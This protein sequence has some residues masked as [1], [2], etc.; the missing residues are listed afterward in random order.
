MT[1]ETAS[2][3]DKINV[4]FVVQEGDA[5]R[6]QRNFSQAQLA[7]AETVGATVANFI[8]AAKSS[9][10]MAIYDFLLQ[11]EAA[12][13]VVGALNAAAQSGKDVRIA[14]FEAHNQ[15]PPES[16][17]LLGGDPAIIDD[18]LGGA[19]LQDA[20]RRRGVR[21]NPAEGTL[22][23]P[24]EGEPITAP[25]NL[26]H[27]KYI[28]RDGLTDEAAVLAGSANFT[29]DAWALQDNNI[30]IL[31]NCQELSAY[32]E[33]DF[34]EM[35]QS[36]LISNTGNFDTAD[37]EVGGIPVQVL[38]A[39]GRGRQIGGE[40]AARIE[41]AKSRLIVASM[42]ISSAPIM[43]AIADRMHRV[44]KFGG[45]F[46]GAEMRMVL[47]EWERSSGQEPRSDTARR[48]AGASTAK[49]QEFREIARFLHYKDSLPFS[50][51]GVHNFMHNKFAIVDD[52]VI[53][54]SFNFST[55]AQ[56]NAENVLIIES[57]ELADAY[58]RY[59]N[60]LFAA[61]PEIGLPT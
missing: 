46:D 4:S 61:Y 34:S 29:T 43:G 48:R 11:G 50:R 22:V 35:W 5:A 19:A 30:V 24:V 13:T 44:D 38:F 37:V 2:A 36:G 12:D 51:N 15:P 47:R 39:P 16:F 17:A 40:V 60:K 58:E 31:T 56:S 32:Y 41:T 42:V 9:I 3:G 1:I 54:G 23:P 25:H 18:G 45:I 53:T 33:N 6:G 52:A 14:Y 49:A 57:K 8:Q 55:N 27:S 26:M 20:V 28:V 59:A 10:H 7:Q 21:E